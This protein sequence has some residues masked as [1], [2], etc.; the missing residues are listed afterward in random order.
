M[1][2]IS[3]MNAAGQPVLV[4][5][6]S[7]EKSEILSTMLMEAGIKHQVGFLGS[8]GAQCDLQFLNLASC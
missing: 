8:A 7:V 5:T 2:E 1:T 4:G 6:T 3:R